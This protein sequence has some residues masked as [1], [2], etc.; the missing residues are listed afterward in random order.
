MNRAEKKQQTIPTRQSK[1]KSWIIGTLEVNKLTNPSPVMITAITTAG[2][3][4]RTVSLTALFASSLF[5]NSSSI[6]L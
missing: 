4:W 6:L 5:A 2:A 3:V 1:P